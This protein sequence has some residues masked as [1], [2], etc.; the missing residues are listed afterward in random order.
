MN[1]HKVKRM[2]AIPIEIVHLDIIKHFA[3]EFNNIRSKE[4][5]I[6]ENTFPNW[7]TLS[8][9]YTLNIINHENCD[10]EFDGSD[11]V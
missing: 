5:Y 6:K 4:K 8:N 7:I 3:N 1:P 9:K 10:I 11:G 2:N